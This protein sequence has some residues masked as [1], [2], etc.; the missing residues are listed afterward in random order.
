MDVEKQEIAIASV[1]PIA[2]STDAN[3][4]MVAPP[5]A[6]SSYNPGPAAVSQGELPMAEQEKVGQKCCGCCCDFRRAVIVMSIISIVFSGLGVIGSIAEADDRNAENQ[7]GSD[8]NSEESKFLADDLRTANTVIG[9]LD[10]LTSICGLVGAII[11]NKYMVLLPAIYS[12]C[13][14]IAVSVLTAQ[15]YQDLEDETGTSIDTP[16]GSYVIGIILTF[17]WVYPN[18][19][20]FYENHRGILTKETYPREEFS[21][22]CVQK[23][24]Y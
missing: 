6:Q 13:S 4:V 7:P 16:A 10:L 24:N 20:F 21:C 19:G 11:Y 2:V 3:A 9:I 22:C 14:F 1:Q 12:I 15:A 17:L 18:I 8:L 23:R 5:M